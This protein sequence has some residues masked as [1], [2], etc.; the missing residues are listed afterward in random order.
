MPEF[1][2]LQVKVMRELSLHESRRFSDM[3]AVTGLTSDD[4]KF[5]LRKL[6]KLGLV[7]KNEEGEY[8]L[9]PEGKELANRFDDIKRVP[10]RQP[11]VTTVLYLRR[12]NQKTG[13]TEYLFLQ[14]LR[15]PFYHFWGVIG[16]PV[17]WGEPFEEAAKRG[18]EEQAGLAVPVTLKGFYRQ[19]DRSPD[20]D[21]LLEDK[22]FIIYLADA[23]SA[24]ASAWL[25][26]NSR[27]MTVPEYLTMSKRFESCYD[28]LKIATGDQL[29]FAENVTDYEGDIY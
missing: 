11:K 12:T 19:R 5:H 13:D 22:L 23:G 17:R 14:R 6:I 26:A 1:H 10:L 28:M 20:L 9:T 21:A 4:F 24:K 3:M 16:Q 7:I 27:W 25:H 15:Q 29:Q 2:K 8:E 18:L